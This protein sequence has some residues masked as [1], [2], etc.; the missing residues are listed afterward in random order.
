MLNPILEIRD[1]VKDFPAGSISGKRTR[2]IDHVCTAVVP[3]EIRGI[4]GESGS[5]KT[6]LARCSLRLLEPSS[7]STYFDGRNL[8][9]LSRAELRTRGV[10]SRWFFRIRILR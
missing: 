1:L 7:G 4:V 5:G 10:N 8:A 9:D 6:T 2:V 3:G